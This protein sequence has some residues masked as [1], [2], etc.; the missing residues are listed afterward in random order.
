MNDPDE[1]MATSTQ[2]RKAG[3]QADSIHSANDGIEVN[4]LVNPLFTQHAFLLT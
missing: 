1:I 4:K 2:Y 3:P